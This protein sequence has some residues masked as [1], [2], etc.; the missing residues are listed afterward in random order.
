MSDG[1]RAGEAPPIAGLR[2]F[3]RVAAGLA[4]IAGFLLFVGAAHTDR[5]FSW[6]IDPQLTAA[7]LGSAYWAACVLL[8]WAAVQ[9]RWDR[10]RVALPPVLVIAVLLLVATLA[11]L[12]KFHL[13]SLF[14]VFWLAV[15]VIVTP[16]LVYLLVLQRQAGPLT[17]GAGGRLPPL[18][19]LLLAAE[20]IVQLGIGAALLVAP[21]GAAGAWPWL[22]T[23]LTGRAIGAF[24]V[25]FGVAAAVA[26]AVGELARYSGPAYSYATLGALELAAVG[27]H[28]SDLTAGDLGRAA[29]VSFWALVLATGVY[30]SIAARA[31]ATSR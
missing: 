1:A 30:G 4:L 17:A 25:G 29:Y 21:V 27:I 10:A 3:F 26:A 28:W 6:T 14:G 11:H 2:W 13:S 19:R 8:A 16:L 7:F 9:D 20:A 23:P 5:F 18:V 22:L 12:D 31:A 15:Y 24:L